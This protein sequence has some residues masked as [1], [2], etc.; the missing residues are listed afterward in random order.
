MPTQ[1][2]EA[3]VRHTNP[4]IAI[5]DLHGE[6][7]AFAEERLFAAYAEAESQLQYPQTDRGNEENQT[8]LPAS[9]DAGNSTTPNTSLSHRASPDGR[10]SPDS[11]APSTDIILLNFSDVDYINSTG[12]ALIVSLLTRARKAHHRLLACGLSDHYAEI[13]QITRLV[14]FIGIFPDE[15]S[16]LAAG[17]GSHS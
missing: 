13:F 10:A 8:S 9:P 4:R 11:L 7:N 1:K 6:I 16:A 3:E 15:A 12:I 2:L 17:S 5:V 14:D